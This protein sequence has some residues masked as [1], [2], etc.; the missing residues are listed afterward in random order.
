[1]IYLSSLRCNNVKSYQSTYVSF[2]MINEALI[3]HFYYMTARETRTSYYISQ[4]KNDLPLSLAN[5]KAKSIFINVANDPI[6]KL[7]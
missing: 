5:K 4:K 3:F 6:K 7:P 1:M 2:M